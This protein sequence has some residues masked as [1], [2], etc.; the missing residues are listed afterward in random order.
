MILARKHC[1]FWNRIISYFSRTIDFGYSDSTSFVTVLISSKTEASQTADSLVLVLCKFIHFQNRSVKF[2]L[3]SLV[4]VLCKFIQFQNLNIWLYSS[5]CR[6]RHTGRKPALNLLFLF[7]YDCSILPWQSYKGI[8][9][10]LLQ[11]LYPLIFPPFR[12]CPVRKSKL[13]IEAEYIQYLIYAPLSTLYIMFM[14]ILCWTSNL[15]WNCAMII[16][17]HFIRH[18][19]IIQPHGFETVYYHISP[20]PLIYPSQAK[21]SSGTVQIHTLPKVIQREFGFWNYVNSYISKTLIKWHTINKEFW[22]YANSYISKTQT[23]ICILSSGFGTMQIHFTVLPVETGTP[24]ANPPWLYFFKFNKILP[25]LSWD[26]CVF[27]PCKA[28]HF[29]TSILIFYSIYE[30]WNYTNSYISKTDI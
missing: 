7:Y 23:H 1:Q 15:F 12:V 16:L 24:D 5:S 19:M 27:E 2:D 30:F 20:L 4:M 18:N 14:S 13:Y 10:S 8:P 29:K 25:I 22:N 3:D 17:I 11:D 28:I 26:N 9:C 21:Q 6:N